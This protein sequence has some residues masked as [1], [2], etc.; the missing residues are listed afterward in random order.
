MYQFY[1]LLNEF[2]YYLFSLFDL[3]DKVILDLI[4]V[5]E[6]SNSFNIHSSNI[7]C[8]FIII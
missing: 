3:A 8:D 6:C 4:R 7:R 2:R 1:L 5:E